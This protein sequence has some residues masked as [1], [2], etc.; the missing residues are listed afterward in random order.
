MKSN[1]K[2]I[3]VVFYLF[4]SVMASCSGNSN[5]NGGTSS[6]AV[7]NPR[8][9]TVTAD[10]LTVSPVSENQVSVTAEQGFMTLGSEL[11][12]DNAVLTIKRNGET[13]VLLIASSLSQA[14]NTPFLSAIIPAKVGDTIDVDVE[15]PNAEGNSRQ[16]AEATVTQTTVRGTSATAT[17]TITN[18]ATDLIDS[19]CDRLVACFPGT[20]TPTACD[21]GIRATR[22][23]AHR[24]GVD[25]EFGETFGVANEG[26]IYFFTEVIT[27][28][29]NGSVTVN[30]SSSCKA[31]IAA[32]PCTGVEQS[33]SSGFNP[34]TPTNY[35]NV[36][37][38]IPDSC[39]SAMSGIPNVSRSVNQLS[40]IVD[41]LC[42]S[43]INCGM[44][45]ARAC[46]DGIRLLGNL[47]NDFG[48]SETLTM[49][50]MIDQVESGTLEVDQDALEACKNG[51][52]D[53]CESLVALSAY[54]TT[55]PNNYTAIENAV[56][57]RGIFTN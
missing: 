37:N 29:E 26:N 43:V 30:D 50:E 36:E 35:E 28:V 55:Q 41:K 18:A 54:D 47:S 34:A 45:T 6:T 42:I 56:N 12:L 14:Q 1:V 23:V 21:E 32:V 3:I 39:Q 46:D 15:I 9:F 20:L 25:N 2:S 49:E 31:D 40:L 48:L 8:A 16:R 27:G 44:T 4:L 11:S 52:P 19:A 22:Q 17:A 5:S 33:V 24:F 51:L 7:G 57:C 38:F 13:H 10:K 53:D